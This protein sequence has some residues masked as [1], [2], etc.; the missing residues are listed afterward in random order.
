MVLSDGDWNVGKSPV[1]AATRFRMKGVAVFAVGVGSK[2]PLA[3]LELVSMDAP[4]F[5]VAGKT[6]RIPF[7]VRSTLGQDRDVTVTLS[8]ASS[9]ENTSPTRQR[10]NTSGA[11]S[12]LAGASRLYGS[13]T[14]VVRV[15]AMGQAQQNLVWT[16]PTTGDYELTMQVP[17]DEQELIAENKL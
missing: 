8:V 7:V 16:P 3:D 4:T 12:T 17:Q 2:V 10:V 9:T 11:D 1:E 6:L 5:G 14:K 15:P 13:I